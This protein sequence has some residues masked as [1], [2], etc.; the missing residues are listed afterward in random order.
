MASLYCNRIL[1]SLLL[2]GLLAGAPVAG[3][4]GRDTLSV[5]FLGNS[6]TYFNNLPGMLEAISEGLDGP[7]LV[8]DS[9]THG[10]Y[11]LRR[12]ADDGHLPGAFGDPGATG[13]QWDVVVLQEQSSLATS[14]D[15]LTGDL[16][17][18]DQFQGAVRDLESVVRG[19]GASP[20]LYMTWAKKRWPDQLEEISEAYRGMGAELDSPVAPVGAAWAAVIDQRPDLELFVADGSHPTPAGSYLAACVIYATLTGESPIGAPREVWGAPW[21]GG[22]PLES[23][24][25]T[26]L[27]SLSP[28][29]AAYLQDVAWAVAGS[30]GRR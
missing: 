26:L 19:L 12:H 14:T 10:G 29:D 11:T 21:S 28:R 22:G 27:V 8:T 18:P 20:A 3:Q 15:T 6:Y 30:E 9:H 13:L 4:E 16:G 25:P 7:R 23:G 24:A 1:R 5:F 2:V 17:S